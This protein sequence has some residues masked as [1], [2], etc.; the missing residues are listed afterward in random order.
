MDKKNKHG[1]RGIYTQV[2]GFSFIFQI[3]FS[4][5]S[6]VSLSEALNTGAMVAGARRRRHRVLDLNNS[7]LKLYTPNLIVFSW[8]LW[9]RALNFEKAY[10][11]SGSEEEKSDE[12]TFS[13]AF[14][15]YRPSFFFFLSFVS[16]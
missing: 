9:I 11:E 15:L 2:P 3:F 12:K 5:N 10:Q 7:K 4:L 16:V 14:V 1:Q 8:W 6:F 13:L